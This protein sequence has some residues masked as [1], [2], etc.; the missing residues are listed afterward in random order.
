MSELINVNDL[1]V[2]KRIGRTQH[3]GI[4]RGQPQRL[5]APTVA[6][7]LSAYTVDERGCWNWSGYCN[8][9][10]YGRVTVHQK[11]WL[12]QR[13]S[14][15]QHIG[16]IPA[17]MIVRQR[18]RNRR[19]INPAHLLIERRRKLTDAQVVEI[20]RRYAMSAVSQRALG[21][22]FGMCQQAIS[23]V[24]RPHIGMHYSDVPT[25]DGIR[26]RP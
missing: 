15:V 1:P 14:Y 5:N 2:V 3:P 20:R 21:E 8:S 16:L 6:E 9:D 17:G 25:D 10:G 26:Y 24:V 18:C 22:E 4:G 13:L 19:C 23:Y 11:L 7:R 12:V